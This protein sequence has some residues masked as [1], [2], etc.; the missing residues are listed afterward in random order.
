MFGDERHAAVDRQVGVQQLQ[1]EH[2]GEEEHHAV[3]DLLLRVTRQHV[4]HHGEHV[5]EGARVEQV[6]VEL[7]P[8]S[9]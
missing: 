1:V 8:P 6:P 5:G 4:C 3:L 2:H 9:P 7:S